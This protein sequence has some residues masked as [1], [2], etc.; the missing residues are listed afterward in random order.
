MI[1]MCANLGTFLILT[2]T[3]L[4]IKRDEFVRSLKG[5]VESCLLAKAANPRYCKLANRISIVRMLSSIDV[6]THTFPAWIK[7]LFGVS[8]LIL[9]RTSG[10]RDI[11][12]CAWLY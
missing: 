2:E 9:Q 3:I 12:W 4:D 7:R 11:S 1:I 10:C 5:E 6:L 8:Q